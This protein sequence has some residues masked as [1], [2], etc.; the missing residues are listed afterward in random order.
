VSKSIDHKLTKKG[1]SL[2]S[3]SAFSGNETPVAGIELIDNTRK[4]VRNKTRIL[5]TFLL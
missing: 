4:S 3:T 2:I 1:A 5:F